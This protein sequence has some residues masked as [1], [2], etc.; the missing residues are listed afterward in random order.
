M[1]S[2]VAWGGGKYIVITYIVIIL[3]KK[4]HFDKSFLIF[5]PYRHF[6]ALN[7]GVALLL[8]EDLPQLRGFAGDLLK[9]FVRRGKKTIVHYY[10]GFSGE[11][12]RI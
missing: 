6:L 1:P 11:E 9:W 2:L 5:Q 10:E 12:G 3:R 4:F 7:I 8:R